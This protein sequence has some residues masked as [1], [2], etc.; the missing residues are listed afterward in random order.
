MTCYQLM[1]K[2]AAVLHESNQESNERNPFN[3]QSSPS[4]SAVGGQLGYGL[5]SLEISQEI[6][7]LL[8]WSMN[9]S[10]AWL[11]AY[12]HEIDVESSAEKKFMAAVV[13]R[14]NHEPIAYIIGTTSFYGHEF[15]VNPAVLIPRAET[16]FL[17]EAIIS[18]L[19]ERNE[20][21]EIQLLE[22][23][24][25]SGCIT[26]CIAL[27]IENIHIKT[28]D[29]SEQALLI[30]KENIRYYG[31][32][33]KIE[34]EQNDFLSE[35]YSD[36]CK[37]DMIITNP[38]YIPTGHIP[39]LSPDVSLYEP[40]VSLDGGDD[41]LAFYRKLARVAKEL[42]KPKGTV[43][44]EIGWDQSS[45]VPGLFVEQGFQ[46]KLIK[47]YSDIVRVVTTI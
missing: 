20:K 19:K 45:A 27:A 30:A 37:Y 29:I 16:E 22:I 6:K 7:I 4:L 14:S 32:D 9:K 1:Q 28:I 47:D 13:R 44:V 11:M 24:T 31:V 46:V 5:N 35:N 39:L 2:G 12:A 33:K 40:L 34:F 23:G 42:L 25:G 18:N 15:K 3:I 41:G 36:L 21:K 8:S 43:A 17:V 26:C 10:I 38:P